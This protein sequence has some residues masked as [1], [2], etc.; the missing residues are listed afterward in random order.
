VDD[1][2]LG[3]EGEL[4]ILIEEGL[5]KA[6]SRLNKEINMVS[7]ISKILKVIR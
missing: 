1:Y 3:N 2:G 4:I 5:Y 7:T 6:Q